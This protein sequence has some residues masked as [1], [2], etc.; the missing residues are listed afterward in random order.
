M[1]HRSVIRLSGILLAALVLGCG[2]D[3]PVAPEVPFDVTPVFIGIDQGSTLQ[4]TATLDGQ[5]VPVTWASSNTAIATVSPTGLVT[6]VAVGL[7]P[8]TATLTSDPTRLRSSSITV[9]AVFGT[10]LT[11][12]VPVTG[13][14]SSGAAGSSVLY[15][16]F[17]PTG[18]TSLLVTTRGGPG[19]L[20]LFVRQGTPPT[21]AAGGFSCV[22]EGGTNDETCTYAAPAS[23]TW[24][25]LL[26]QFAPYSGV[27]LTATRSP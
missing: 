16:I 26:V 3:D 14:S 15:R 11:S 10:G 24:Y 13:L 8:V 7:T 25:I 9:L 21:T 18:A 20:D 4:L 27:T 22:S 5:P 17:V 19:D 1:T 6:G 23:G 12:G 2:D